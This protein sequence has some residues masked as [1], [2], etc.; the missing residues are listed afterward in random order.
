MT[1][2]D[3]FFP[4]SFLAS[5]FDLHRLKGRVTRGGSLRGRLS[6]RLSGHLSG[7]LSGHLSGRPRGHLS[8]IL[9][10]L[11]GCLS[12]SAVIRGSPQSGS[13][14]LVRKSRSHALNF[15]HMPI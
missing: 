10:D 8:G 3:A 4:V 12:G 5:P 9:F 13:V 11:K 6:G 14:R 2:S 1:F 7:R 15:I